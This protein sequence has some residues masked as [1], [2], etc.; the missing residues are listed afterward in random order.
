MAG[1]SLIAYFLQFHGVELRFHCKTME[2]SS[3]EPGQQGPGGSGLSIH[4]VYL[5]YNSTELDLDCWV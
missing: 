3:M 2:T 5:A 4:C 1:G